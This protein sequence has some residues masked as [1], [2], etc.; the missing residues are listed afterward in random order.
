MENNKTKNKWDPLSILAPIFLQFRDAARMEHLLEAEGDLKAQHKD[1]V[2][3]EQGL[4]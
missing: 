1:V 2:Q 3:D 4:F